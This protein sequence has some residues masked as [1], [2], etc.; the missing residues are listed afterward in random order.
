MTS[1]KKKNP[2]Q[3]FHQNPNNNGAF[4][5]KLDNKELQKQLEQTVNLFW[6]N[7]PYV[8]DLK[9]YH[10]LEVKF[11]TKGIK[12]LTKIDYDN[13]ICKL[14]SLGFTCP[15]PQGVYML[16]IYHEYLNPQTGTVE[17][18]RNIRT[19]INGFHEIQSYCKHNDLNKLVSESNTVYFQN[20]SPYII[21]EDIQTRIPSHILK[22]V[23]FDD[24][25][26]RVSYQKETNMSK[27][28][29]II[30]NIIDSWEKTKKTFRYINRVTFTHPDI[31]IKVDISIVKSSTFENRQMKSTYTTSE[32]EVFTNQEIYEI[33]LEI[34]NS[35]IGPGKKTN[36]ANLLLVGI[37]KAIKFILMGLQ[38]TNYPISYPEQNQVL[39]DYM[40]MIIPDKEFGL[41]DRVYPSNFIGPSSYTLQIP[42]IAPINENSNLPNIRTKY[43]VT[44]KADGERHMLFINKTKSYDNSDIGKIYLI[45]TNMKVIFTGACTANKDLFNTLLDGEIILHDKHGQFIN[46]Y[47][48]FDVYFIDNNDIR[49]YGFIPTKADDKSSKCRLPLLKNV[50]KL[51]N[52]I[53]IV[54][55]ESSPMR[56]ESKNFYPA[57]MLDENNNNIFDACN[58]ILNK[59]SEGLFDY[60]TDGLIFTPANMGVGSD[61]IGIPSP[62]KKI[63]WIYSFKWKPP[64]YNT[65]DFLV[66]TVKNDA[67]LD[68]VTTTFQDGINTSAVIQL[69]EYKTIILRCGF[70]EQEDGYVNPCNNVI[71]DILPVM[72]NTDNENG[73]KASNDGY[74][75]AQF[76]PTN[77]S[78]M[79]A[80]ICNIMLKK[81]GSGTNQMFTESEFEI[82][83][84][85]NEGGI[86]Q[87]GEVFVDNT[88]VE[89]KYDLTKEPKMRWIPIKV[90]YDKTN[91]LRQGL[92]NFG[93]AY[94]VANS[95]WHSIHNP[96]TLEMI[97]TGKGIPDEIA[98][99][100]IYYNN[101]N[102][103][104]RNS[105]KT[106]ALR[107]F[108]NLYVKQL[109]ITS[110]A[111]RGDT[112][113]DY[114]CGKGGDFPKW[115]KAQLSFVFGIDL[116][117][118]NIENRLN[119]AC[120]RFLNFR[121]EFKHVPYALFVNGNSNNNIRS[122][123][124]MLS[125]KAAHIT[126][127]VFGIGAKDEEKL[128]KGVMRQYGKGEDGFNISSCQFALHYFSENQTTFQ[129]FIRNV[130][131]CTKIGG[132]FIG[133]CY[134][135]RKIFNLLKNTNKG[136][137]INIYEG[138]TKIWEIQK[139]YDNT[140]FDDNATSLGFKINVFQE[141][142]NKMFSEY[143]IN[144]DYLQSIMENYGFRLLTRDESHLIGLPQGSGSFTELYNNMLEDIAR[145]KFN[146]RKYGD[147]F[148]MSVY[149]S[150]I[151][152][153]NRYFV[154]K[155]INNV[156]A[157]KVASNIIEETIESGEMK[158]VLDKSEKHKDKD[159]EMKI[160]SQSEEK[161]D[162]SK[163][164]SKLEGKKSNEDK[165]V[166]IKPK[167]RKL[168][169]KLVLL[170]TDE[171]FSDTK[172]EKPVELSIEKVV[173]EK[174]EEVVE[175]VVEEKAEEVVEKEKNPKKAKLIKTKKMKIIND[176]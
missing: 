18:S 85:G 171:P 134:D 144:F 145:N 116:S 4:R 31:P 42:N 38:G 71:N 27:D 72:S 43:T 2:D 128:G 73:H 10:E 99:D 112:L 94:R 115:I 162:K 172:I 132:Y 90:R 102:K 159:K 69:N 117:N 95:N 123:A 155:K 114:A 92:K 103:S 158:H 68:I 37:R 160:K 125:N 36:S 60:N 176:D 119:G 33:E 39:R 147:A 45:N 34:D 135:G 70:N 150:R 129:N 146:K 148:N 87:G 118:D 23:N 83:G 47:A 89:F 120:A 142:I 55:S 5:P 110:V 106:C 84:S 21:P 25:N 166:Y 174:A 35:E 167:V 26:F 50:I 78:D 3:K 32:S 63:S 151:S 80:G 154:Y 161:K 86:G 6:S 76:Y 108:H 133:T 57:N 111:K 53:S 173:E 15:N 77:P 141:S 30:K 17:L 109:L 153:L 121:K 98:D 101:C 16:R 175:K 28:N 169:K 9:I 20:K 14:K 168:N 104:D 97:S 130:S 131:E 138:D 66:T 152:A 58:Y 56:I 82:V 105:S 124:A 41:H 157:E 140:T 44:D 51:L 62:S 143:L 79:S 88:I 113:I 7:D 52:P 48:A 170:A 49:P 122:G 8:K 91:E 127:A 137:S 46:L 81:D 149:E 75:A 156:N 40:K 139:E 65:I 164:E 12:P 74:K 24:F 126:R 22:P 107:D 54:P 61:R 13:V 1:I 100:D 96:I 59:E 67:G 29:K 136:D 64:Q 19:E 93:N 163:K 11:G 165:E